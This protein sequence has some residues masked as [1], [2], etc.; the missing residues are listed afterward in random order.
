MKSCVGGV[1]CKEFLVICVVNLFQSHISLSII[2]EAWYLPS[3]PCICTIGGWVCMVNV[4]ALMSLF[5]FHISM[6]FEL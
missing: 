2:M 3:W 1:S 4:F 6:V 5:G